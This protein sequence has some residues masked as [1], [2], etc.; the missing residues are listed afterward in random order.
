MITEA[1][2]LIETRRN[3]I[4]RGVLLMDNEPQ[5]LPQLFRRSVTE[6]GLP[7]ALNYK[8]G[9]EWRSISSAKMV[10]RAENIALGMYSLGLRKGDRA[11]ILA[12]NSPEWT[13]SDAGCQFAGVVDVPVYTTLSPETV[14]YI[15][16]DS[17]AR[18]LFLKDTDTYQRLL[19]ALEDCGSIFKF[20]LFDASIEADDVVSL[21]NLELAWE[22]L[23]EK[24][25]LL[26][27]KN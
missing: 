10:E 9:D 6:Y 4:G 11:A 27:Y 19:P 3:P 1:G 14:R 24:R 18:I 21:E 17:A 23:S 12:P 15:I 5:T 2:N 13:L 20:I 26:F 8:D 16:D 22:S 25:T 7:D